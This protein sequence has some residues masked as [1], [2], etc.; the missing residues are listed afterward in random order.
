MARHRGKQELDFQQQVFIKHKWYEVRSIV[1]R[2]PRLL[3]F[4]LLLFDLTKRPWGLDLLLILLRQDLLILRRMR[5]I[6]LVEEGD[7]LV[8][9]FREGLRE[10]VHD[11]CILGVEE[12]LQQE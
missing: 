5:R 3:P 4:G 8:F 9:G 10:N 12:K 2:L 11:L 6:H 1:F 7:N